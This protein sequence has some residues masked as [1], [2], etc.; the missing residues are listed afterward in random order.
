MLDTC[1]ELRVFTIMPVV[2]KGPYVSRS[3]RLVSLKCPCRS[4][5]ESE[6]CSRGLCL[7]VGHVFELSGIG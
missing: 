4:L 3:S 2:V 6:T 1:T 7:I 5:E